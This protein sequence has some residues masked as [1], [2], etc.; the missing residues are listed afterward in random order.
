MQAV[1]SHFQFANITKMSKWTDFLLLE[2]QIALRF[3]TQ[4]LISSE[5]NSCSNSLF[6][7][8]IAQ[9]IASIV[10]LWCDLASEQARMILTGGL[11]LCH[12]SKL[13]LTVWACICPHSCDDRRTPSFSLLH[14]LGYTWSSRYAQSLI[15]L[16]FA[17]KPSVDLLLG[18]N[19]DRFGSQTNCLSKTLVCSLSFKIR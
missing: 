14:W 11:I 10:K 2:W 7:C 3:P 17:L 18:Q 12:R 6:T 19:L 9:A 5:T 4:A 13:C 1:T 8:Q 16:L 15:C